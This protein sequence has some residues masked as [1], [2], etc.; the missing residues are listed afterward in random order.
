MRSGDDGEEIKVPRHD[1][2][3]VSRLAIPCGPAKHTFIEVVRLLGQGTMCHSSNAVTIIW[4]FL[5]LVL[6]IG[7]R[8]PAVGNSI[9]PPG[10]VRSKEKTGIINDKPVLHLFPGVTHRVFCHRL[11]D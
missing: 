6:K 3:K 8:K 7:S 11:K 9:D 4:P 2:V 5:C 10:S 1:S